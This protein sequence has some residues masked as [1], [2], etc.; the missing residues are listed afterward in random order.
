MS[1]PTKLDVIK[2]KLPFFLLGVITGMLI[3]WLAILWVP[4]A[5]V[6]ALAAAGIQAN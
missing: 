3:V 4:G 1:E 6:S 2:L 5:M